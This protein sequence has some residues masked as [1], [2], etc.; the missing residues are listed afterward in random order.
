[1]RTRVAAIT[2]ALGGLALALAVP[3]QAKDFTYTTW[4]TPA[5]ATMAAGMA[6]FFKR[7]EADTGGEFK[8]NAFTAG[9]LAGQAATL[10]AVRDRVADSGFVLEGITPKE[11]PFNAFTADFQFLNLDPMA[12][13][14]AKMELALFKCP[15]CQAEY[16]KYNAMNLGG[17]SI[18]VNFLMCTRELKTVDDIAKL[19]I[20]TAL[21]VYRD[22]TTYFGGTPVFT[23]FP[24][25]VPALQTG[26]AHCTIGNTAWM[27]AYGL[28]DMMKSIVTA[29]YIG[30]LPS[31]STFT[32]N[33]DAWN[34][35]SPKVK[36]AILRNLPKVLTGAT[37][38]N[39]KQGRD[40]LQAGLASGVKVVDLGA[41]F[42]SKWDAFIADEP[43]RILKA[44]VASGIKRE[45]AQRILDDYAQL[46]K[47]WDAIVKAAQ[48][49]TEK[50][51]QALWDEVYSKLKL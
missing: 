9:Q 14:A 7:V 25:M 51:D 49:D 28:R 29:R 15:E 30:A 21:R 47:K 13:A 43:E 32:V 16:K 42:T 35:L 18:D 26:Q 23:T 38:Y 1:M 17:H 40:G 37:A 6:P 5:E 48:G 2:A 46:Y 8:A 10:T 50:I 12:S 45:V 33:R 20:R 3:V 41:T 27:T 39:T 31:H 36:Q 4:V 22:I 11:T 24:E 44:A 19:R 34:E